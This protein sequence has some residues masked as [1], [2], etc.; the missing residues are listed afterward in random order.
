MLWKNKKK[1]FAVRSKIVSFASLEAENEENESTLT[2][3]AADS[4]ENEAIL[5][6]E[7]ILVRKL[8][9]ELPEKL[10]IPLYLNY[11]AEMSADE[12]AKKLQKNLKK[13]L[14]DN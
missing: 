9:A 11:S 8:V 3:Y 6:N 13:N 12:I 10:R 2:C 7:A 14:E 1:K 4:A 5:H